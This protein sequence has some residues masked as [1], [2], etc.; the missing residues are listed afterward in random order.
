MTSLATLHEEEREQKNE[1]IT[2]L[3]QKLRETED[4]LKNARSRWDKESAI[5][6]Q[7]QDFLEVQ[8]KEL[9][10]QLDETRKTHESMVKAI[11]SKDHENAY[12]KEMADKQISDL[13]EAHMK[14]VRELEGE[15]NAV[16]KRLTSQVDQLTERN[17][18]YSIRQQLNELD[19]MDQSYFA[20][21][22]EKAIKAKVDEVL[23]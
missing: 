9:R 13:K 2:E 15:F 16:R 23:A 8:L 11:Q 3:E 18:E 12:G 4:T 22:R 14:E 7:K 21:D 19:V 6:K 5:Q 20:K 10:N 17:S 1:T